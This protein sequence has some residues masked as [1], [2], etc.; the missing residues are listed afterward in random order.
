M[1]K[2]RPDVALSSGFSDGK[3][4]GGTTIAAAN[5]TATATATATNAN[6]ATA[7]TSGANAGSADRPYERTIM[8][9]A[10]RLASEIQGLAARRAQI[11]TMLEEHDR[12]IMQKQAA[13]EALKG[14]LAAL[15]QPSAQPSRVL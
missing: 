4:A 6:A 15:A 12:A 5:A 9:S 1:L 10:Q 14:V 8:E 13:L 11:I 7:S 3:T 2:P